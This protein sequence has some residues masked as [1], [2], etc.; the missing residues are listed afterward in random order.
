MKRILYTGSIPELHAQF[1]S[2]VGAQRQ[3]DPLAPL[4]VV[5][6]GHLLRLAIKRDLARA[7]G[8]HAH[9]RFF[10]LSDLIRDTIKPILRER[11]LRRLRDIA[12]SPLMMRAVENAGE[13]AYFGKIAHRDG[14]QRAVWRT[15]GELRGA[16]LQRNDLQRA[17]D[18]LKKSSAQTA[19]YSKLR[20]LT[21]IWTELSALM[22]R[23]GL[24]DSHDILELA[25]ANAQFD[26]SIPVIFYGFHELS[27]QEQAF[28]A[29]VVQYRTA[30][31]YL[32]YD[33]H[34]ASKWVEPLFEFFCKSGFTV[35][36]AAVLGT[37]DQSALSQLQRN[38][39]GESR[40][41][42]TVPTAHDQSVHVLSAP[43]REREA[44][45]I[46]RAL[47]YSPLAETAPRRRIGVLLRESEPYSRLLRDELN[48]A[49][50]N[51]YFHHCR[52][53]GQTTGGR[54]LQLLTTLLDE[55]F[56]RADVMEFLLSSPVK[57]P[58]DLPVALPEIPA[59]EWNHFSLLA[60]ITSGVGMWEDG[61]RRLQRQW[62]AQHERHRD[63]DD[64][65]D[66]VSRNRLV[67]L[68]SMQ[69]YLQSLFA[70][71]RAVNDETTWQGR[72]NALWQLLTDYIDTGEETAEVEA[73]LEHAATLDELDFDLNRERF[74]AMIRSALSTPAEREGHFQV[75]EPTVVT[76]GEAMGVRFDE[77]YI[78]GMV[79]KEIPRPVPQDP[80]LLDEDR[81]VIS[82]LIK[83]DIPTRERER[84]RD[85]FLFRAAVSGAQRRIVLSLPRRDAKEGRE[86]LPSSFLLSTIETLRGIR[87]DYEGLD[88]WLRTSP[89]ATRI[90]SGRLLSHPL[91]AAT[92]AQ[93]DIGQ[94]ASALQ[95]HS[96][97]PLIDLLT[98]RS[99]FARGIESELQ[100]YRTRD[101]TRYE[102]VIEDT[103][104]R[105]QLQ[106][107][108]NPQE[109]Q[110][111]PTRLESYAACPFQFFVLHLLELESV[112][113]P[114]AVQSLPPL[115]RGNLIHDIL[116]QFYRQ[117]H[118]A[119]RLPLRNGSEERLIPVAEDVF[120]RF[121]ARNVT[122]P[123]LLW[124][125]EQRHII[126]RL[127]QFVVREANSTTRFV[128]AYFEVNY[129]IPGGEPPSSPDPLPF[130]LSDGTV[131]RFHGRIDR[132]D[133]SPEGTARVLD[134]KTGSVQSRHRN[135]DL[136]GGRA[137]QLPVYRL[138][139]EQ[140]LNL[141]VE[142][143]EYRFLL[144]DGNER[145]IEFSGDDW[146]TNRDDFIRIIQT[147]YSGISA[148]R[149]FP[150]PEPEQ[151]RSCRVRA[152]C[153][154]GRMTVKWQR[155]SEIGRAFQALR[156]ERL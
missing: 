148:G 149:Y 83:H 125:I 41:E 152:A 110:F 5:V 51:G 24:A 128:P 55:R 79:E 100:R 77:V 53:L 130:A 135:G 14:F 105:H 104:L 39:F 139:A 131:L 96:V 15:L 61:L 116:E 113:E 93:Y 48:R 59:A 44:E 4:D 2:D 119:G 132:L 121:A 67:S 95:H 32:P 98:D 73:Q 37:D 28:A 143:A 82:D 138:A 25:I 26:R 91:S 40:S 47:L 75:H 50:V 118:H 126:E 153:G 81:Q 36:A 151:C 122:P 49:G 13:L 29:R 27:R 8:G 90:P 70:R 43:S 102:G 147:I 54:A 115:E 42:E 57:W 58:D 133:I 33:N 19:L 56:R 117:E 141:K 12:R 7:I 120:Q 85:R 18:R 107:F 6:P 111:A 31:V 103:V 65:G 20:D 144:R 129:G 60:G 62:E 97:A 78:P 9:V 140:L 88:E 38:L 154:T 68:R 3:N 23:H 145:V 146:E 72:T 45:E 114:E 66:V 10:L 106:K 136:A 142:A 124:T 46:V 150:Y 137:L 80:L 134:Y 156:E 34:P 84:L 52:T 89:F 74:A 64:N 87:T 69:T 123:L 17:A 11:K 22:N 21:A 94:L 155:Q 112:P 99:L 92:A 109:R 127:K 86:R 16:G 63:D 30:T 101:F 108:W 71:L 1:I 35:Q 76:F